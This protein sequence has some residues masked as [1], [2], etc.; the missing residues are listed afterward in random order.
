MPNCNYAPSSKG[1]IENTEAYWKR[2]VLNSRLYKSVYIH[3]ACRG[4]L[5]VGNIRYSWRSYGRSVSVGGH[6][7]KA[8]ANYV[9]TGK[10]VSKYELGAIKRNAFRMRIPAIWRSI[11]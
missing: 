9:D 10:P 2:M 4:G 11:A 3:A 6:Q 8:Y 7:H 1:P 5:T